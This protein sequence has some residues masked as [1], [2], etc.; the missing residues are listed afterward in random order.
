MYRE[1]GTRIPDTLGRLKLADHM[2]SS[3]NI[4]E[5]QYSEYCQLAEKLFEMS[6]DQLFKFGV[7]PR[8]H[9][10]LQSRVK[11]LNEKT[12]EQLELLMVSHQ[13]VGKCA[14]FKPLPMRLKSKWMKYIAI[15]MKMYSKSINSIIMTKFAP[16]LKA[17]RRLMQVFKEA[18]AYLFGK[19]YPEGTGAEVLLQTTGEQLQQALLRRSDDLEAKS[20]ELAKQFKNFQVWLEAK[21]RLQQAYDESTKT[22][23]EAYLS[24]ILRHQPT[25]MQPSWGPILKD[26]GGIRIGAYKR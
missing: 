7:S 19:I 22:W 2:S 8:E 6:V 21:P 14:Y 10:I 5:K 12:V 18:K 1:L 16:L 20:S 23:K 13:L 11:Q 25:H 9:N 24:A 3:I 17:G 4:I 15:L 26:L